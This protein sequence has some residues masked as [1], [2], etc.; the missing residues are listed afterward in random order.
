MLVFCSAETFDFQGHGLYLVGLCHV[1]AWEH[2]DELNHL[3]ERILMTTSQHC[4]GQNGRYFAD[5]Q[6]DLLADVFLLVELDALRERISKVCAKR[7]S[8]EGKC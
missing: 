4:L 2:F 7:R 6:L 5:L 8:A 1:S 3:R